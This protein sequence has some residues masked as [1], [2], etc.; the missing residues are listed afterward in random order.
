MNKRFIFPIWKAEKIEKE[1][2]GIEHQGYRL[3][4]VSQFGNYHFIPC[5][6]RKSEYVFTLFYGKDEISMFSTEQ[7]LKE[8]GGNEIKHK[9][10]SGGLINKSIFRVTKS[11]DLTEIRSNRDIQ[12]SGALFR[13]TLLTAFLFVLFFVP[14]VLNFIF[15]GI[16]S[17]NNSYNLFMLIILC[18][19]CVIT[20]VFLIY[21]VSGYLYLKRKL[22]IK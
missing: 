19:C 17:I 9:S 13:N 20:V 7:F 1:L 4:S 2:S 5:T 10:L 15:H 3:D 18:I 14:M 21:N 16:E 6:P 12:L 11:I 22:A 8:N